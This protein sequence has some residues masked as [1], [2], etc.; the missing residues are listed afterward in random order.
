MNYELEK[1]KIIKTSAKFI[2]D[3]PKLG[4]FFNVIFHNIKILV[5][6]G[7]AGTSFQLV[8]FFFFFAQSI[9]INGVGGKKRHI[10]K[11]RIAAILFTIHRKL[12][13]ANI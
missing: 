1:Q 11:T 9:A 4:N 3:N 8:F 6:A 10:I 13:E 5:T 7:T 12:C 2:Y